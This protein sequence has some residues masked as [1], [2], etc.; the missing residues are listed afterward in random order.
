MPPRQAANEAAVL[1]PAAANGV[2]SNAASPVAAPAESKPADPNIRF[3]FDGLPY[4][5]W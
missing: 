4:W 3:Q 1:P 2:S 5:T